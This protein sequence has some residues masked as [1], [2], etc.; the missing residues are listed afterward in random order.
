MSSK[1]NN[2][3]TKRSRSTKMRKEIKSQTTPRR[4][5]VTQHQING[6]RITPPTNPPDVTFQPWNVI[7]LVHAF[8]GSQAYQAKSLMA[9]LRSQIDPNSHGFNQ[10]KSG[11]GRFTLQLKI[12]SIRA[13]N[14]SGRVIALSVDD[15]LDSNTAKGANEQLCGLVDTG[16]TTHT[17]AVGYDLPLTHRSHVIRTDDDKLGDTYIFTAQVGS[18]DQGLSYIKLAY[19]FDGPI[20]A[21]LYLLPVDKLISAAHRTSVSTAESQALL[22]TMS[23]MVKELKSIAQ[24][25]EEMSRPSLTSR[26]I[27]GIKTT[28]MVVS[29]LASDQQ[30]LSSSSSFIDLQQQIEE[31]SIQ[32]G[33][34]VDDKDDTVRSD[35]KPTH[36][37]KM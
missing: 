8:K 15:F 22:E 5:T 23:S 14:L 30:N 27:D 2:L 1:G 18:N 16:T 12:F 24:R 6:G 29:M 33:S 9:I 19:R 35:E 26:I 25:N 36:L 17:P 32:L 10:T 21:P 13:W 34:E 37:P 7:T 28:G 4:N 11:E 31:L 20:K 3:T